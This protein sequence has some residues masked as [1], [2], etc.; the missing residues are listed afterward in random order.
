M[1][2][3]IGNE[4][5]RGSAP[6]PAGGPDVLQAFPVTFRPC[7]SPP[8]TERFDGIFFLPEMAGAEPRDGGTGV[9]VD[10]A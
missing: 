2:L 3:G 1:G 7:P 9:N 8:A 10:G 6:D 4:T 5:I